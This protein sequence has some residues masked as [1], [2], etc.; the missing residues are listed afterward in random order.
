METY[1]LDIYMFDNL[2][3]SALLAVTGLVIMS[4]IVW[5]VIRG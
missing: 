1:Y 2:L 5:W 3:L 4:K